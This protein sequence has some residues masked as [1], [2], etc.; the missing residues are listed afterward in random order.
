MEN[1]DSFIHSL[2]INSEL[3]TEWSR[4]S[5]CL[6]LKSFDHIIVKKG[7]FCNCLPLFPVTSVLNKVV[8]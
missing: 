3:S 1:K 8:K 6:E 2:F 4:L 7:L 5:I